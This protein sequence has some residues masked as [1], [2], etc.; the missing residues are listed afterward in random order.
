MA[1]ERLDGVGKVDFD[2]CIVGLQ[3][4]VHHVPM[5]KRT[6][7]LSNSVHVLRLFSGRMCNKRHEHHTLQGSEG[8][9]SRAVWAQ[10]YPG[11]MVDLL[12]QSAL[13]HCA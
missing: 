8:G 3:S 5:R 12:A 9:M 7:L 4:K 2:Q 10:M 13:S 11:P 6:R 1:V